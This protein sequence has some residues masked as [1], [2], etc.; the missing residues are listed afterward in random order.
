M[1]L[2]NNH[3]N[4]HCTY[5]IVNVIRLFFDFLVT[6]L[7]QEKR[8]TCTIKRVNAVAMP[9]VQWPGEARGTVDSR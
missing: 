3:F 7:R 1:D 9:T 6:L 4:G 2:T 5:H 8:V